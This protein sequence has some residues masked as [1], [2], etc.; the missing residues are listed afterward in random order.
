VL[1]TQVKLLEGE[2]QSKVYRDEL[3]TLK[4]DIRKKTPRA[5][6][7]SE[8]DTNDIANLEIRKDDAQN[9]FNAAEKGISD[10]RQV[11]MSRECDK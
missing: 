1:Q 5:G 11:I 6:Q 2:L 10:A 4:A 9:K 7:I 8:K 3:L